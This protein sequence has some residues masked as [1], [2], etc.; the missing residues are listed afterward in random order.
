MGKEQVGDTYNFH[1]SFKMSDARI[2]SF[3]YK[4]LRMSGGKRDQDW[5]RGRVLLRQQ[6]GGGLDWDDFRF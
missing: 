2:N 1:H 6:F 4:T 3:D 5:A